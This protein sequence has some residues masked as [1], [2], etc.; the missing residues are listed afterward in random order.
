MIDIQ[1]HSTEINKTSHIYTVRLD[2]RLLKEVDQ[3]FEVSAGSLWFRFFG[4]IDAIAN[5]FESLVD[6]TFHLAL[7]DDEEIDRK[8][9]ESVLSRLS[10]RAAWGEHVDMLTS[11]NIDA[12]S[13]SYENLTSEEEVRLP[14]TEERDRLEQIDAAFKNMLDTTGFDEEMQQDLATKIVMDLL[15]GEFDDDQRGALATVVGVWLGNRVADLTGLQ[16]HCIDE[17]NTVTYC[18][19]NPV[20]KVSCFP[21]DAINK[22]LNRQ[23]AFKPDLLAATFADGLAASV[24]SCRQQ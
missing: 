21:F 24:N 4:E 17:G 13:I 8:F 9:G 12:I 23:E 1:I 2:S 6:V 7:A 15:I 5:Q 11:P 22:R 16:W 10:K 18:I 20:R 14:T 19:H 3:N